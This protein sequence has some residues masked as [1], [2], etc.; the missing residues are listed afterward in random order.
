MVFA[1]A[2]LESMN[3]EEVIRPHLQAVRDSTGDSS[4]LAVLSGEDIL[5]LLHVSTNRMVRLAAGIGTRFPP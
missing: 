4:S 3:L 2:F 1:S 5:Y